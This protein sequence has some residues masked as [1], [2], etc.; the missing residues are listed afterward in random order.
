MQESA[1]SKYLR[2][3]YTSGII[4]KSSVYGEKSVYY[5]NNRYRQ[6]LLD[7]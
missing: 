1:V 3:L 4:V 2:E 7:T 6:I 5:V